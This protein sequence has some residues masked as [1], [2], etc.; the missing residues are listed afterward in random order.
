MN[1]CFNKFLQEE[2]I[3]I[4]HPTWAKNGSQTIQMTS[5]TMKGMKPQITKNTKLM[6]NC[7]KST[8]RIEPY[9]IQ[10]IGLWLYPILFWFSL[11]QSETFLSFWQSLTTRV[12]HFYMPREA[13]GTSSRQYS[14]VDFNSWFYQLILTVNFNNWF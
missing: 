8:T 12:S 3:W 7:L 6:S 13:D 14:P 11:D 5:L 2:W 9:Q 4:W 10:P 1:L